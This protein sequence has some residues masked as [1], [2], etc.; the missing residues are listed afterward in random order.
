MTRFVR[1]TNCQNDLAKSNALYN[2]WLDMYCTAIKARGMTP[3]LVSAMPRTGVGRYSES[4]A[5]PN[6]FLPDSP[7]NMRQKAASDPEVGFIELYEGAKAYIDKLDAKEI[8]YI[9]NNTEAGETPAENAANG[10]KS[11]GT[12]Y[13]EAASKQWN[14]IMLQS[15]YDQAS[16][17]ADAYTDKDIMQR[18][19]SYMP[20]SVQNAAR[21]G[22]W[23]AV[24]PEM[25]TDVSAVDVVPG[26]V[27]QPE[28][29]Y[30]YRNN[31]EKALQLGLLHKNGENIFKPSD[32]ITVGDFARG[33][34]KAFGLAEN[35]LTGYT[36][37][38]AQLNAEGKTAA[39]NNTVLLSD[40]HSVPA[41]LA[42]SGNIA[43]TVTQPEGGTVTV[44]NESAFHTQ[45]VDIGQGVAI[46]QLISDNDYFTLTA[47]NV[48]ENP[49]KFENKSDK[50]A[51]FA[52]QEIS[53][54]YISLRNSGPAM[55]AEY[56]AKASGVLTMYL[57]FDNTKLI[58]CENIT[59]GTQSQTYIEGEKADAANRGN[60]YNA[61]N[62]NVESG[63]TYRLYTNGGTGRLFGVMYQSTDY[64][65]STSALMVNSGDVI[66]VVAE[67]AENYLNKSLLVNG[68]QAAQTK[69]YTF[70]VTD[71]VQVSAEFTAEPAL[72]E[73][74]VIPADAA[75][76]REAM[77]AI[78]YD[79]YLLKM[80]K[81]S[82]GK[83]NKYAYMNQNGNVP[84]PDDPNYD[85]NIQYEGTPYVP[86][87]GWGAL[88]DI[89]DIESSLYQKVKEAYNLGLLRTETGISRGTIENRT[90]LEP[91]AQVTRAKAAKA[92]VFV[93]TLTQP[94]KSANHLLPDGINHGA[95][96]AEFTAVNPDA[97]AVPVK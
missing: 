89:S 14:R 60:R 91:K 37:T 23:S 16:G 26:A 34:E 86:L 17:A 28:A 11:D 85:P 22:N 65:Q 73:T 69:E 42:G 46:G 55:H 79:A 71:A 7:G 49:E 62:F 84:S 63:K 82:S 56:A 3:V 41:A 5:K 31:I 64:P 47:P 80:G 24:F 2:E 52:N 48:T 72:D 25:A 54:N 76:T 57:M 44:Y 92:L 93:F 35:A 4:A 61:V 45:T 29:N 87:T 90:E 21:T 27:K 6:G 43:V 36:K 30:Y 18:L 66:R 94:P 68:V 51:G 53:T 15:I 67:P 58:T 1:G 10:A 12:H 39:S 81:D 83:W 74:T 78:L 50:N 40:I 95:E 38:A 13:K 88:E 8:S 77:G 9:Y 33:A 97:A 70:T 32:V 19:I 75:L 59:D 96:T 20:E